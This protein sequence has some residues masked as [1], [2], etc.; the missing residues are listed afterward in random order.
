MIKPVYFAK[1]FDPMAAIPLIALTAVLGY[2]FGFL[3]RGDLE[4]TASSL[5]ARKKGM[6]FGKQC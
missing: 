1:P 3:R 2:M 6:A 5:S 4:Q